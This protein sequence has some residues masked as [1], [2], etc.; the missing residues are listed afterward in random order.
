MKETKTKKKTVREKFKNLK[1]VQKAVLAILSVAVVSAVGLNLLKLAVYSSQ[2]NGEGKKQSS[3]DR[4]DE[5]VD[6]ELIIIN[7]EDPSLEITYEDPTLETEDNEEDNKTTS[8]N[9]KE[10]ETIE[11]L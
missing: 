11:Q 1:P 4:R 3:V 9:K 10:I 7:P 2:E 8:E 5:T 6:S